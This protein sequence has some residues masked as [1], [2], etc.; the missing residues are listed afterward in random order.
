MLEKWLRVGC[1]LSLNPDLDEQPTCESYS[2][3]F[4]VVKKG[5]QHFC[6]IPSYI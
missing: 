3:L 4:C 6:C 1:L 2:L 5:E